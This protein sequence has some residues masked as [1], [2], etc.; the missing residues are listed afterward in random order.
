MGICLRHG[1]YGGGSS[2][3]ACAQDEQRH[4]EQIDEQQRSARLQAE[5][6]RQ[7]AREL[8]ESNAYTAANAWRLRASA[9]TARAKELF[10]AGLY[11]DAK[12]LSERA[13]AEDPG[14]LESRLTLAGALDALED[15]AGYEHAIDAAAHLVGTP[16]WNDASAFCVTLG[17]IRVRRLEGAF[18]EAIRHK[19]RVFS[20]S[21]NGITPRLIEEAARLGWRDEVAV[22][23]PEMKGNTDE[24][25]LLDLLY[26]CE[27]AKEAN[28][29]ALSI[30]NRALNAKKPNSNEWLGGFAAAL[31]LRE[32]GQKWFGESLV[33]RARLWNTTAVVEVLRRFHADE[34]WRESHIARLF[35]SSRFA[36]CVG[37]WLDETIAAAPDRAVAAGPSPSIYRLALRAFDLDD[38]ERLTRI[39]AT[40]RAENDCAALAG[41]TGTET[42]FEPRNHSSSLW[43][44]SEVAVE[45]AQFSFDAWMSYCQGGRAVERKAFQ[46]A[47]DHYRH[48]AYLFK[49]GGDSVWLGYSLRQLGW[50]LCPDRNPDGNWTNAD[51]AFGKAADVAHASGTT[52]TRAQAV[53]GRAWCHEPPNNPAGDWTR[54]IAFYQE[55]AVLAKDAGDQPQEAEALHAQAWCFAH[56]NN[57][58]DKA[59]SLYAR[60][61]RVWE[62]TGQQADVARSLYGQARALARDDPKNVGADVRLLLDRAIQAR[63]AV[64][65]RKGLREIE[66]WLLGGDSG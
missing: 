59:S 65:D 19:L 13:V 16:D 27:C 9:M 37:R 55:A 40:A 31:R 32:H 28:K 60:A 12:N 21:R 51:I 52:R 66:N 6:Q 42:F 24:F 46:T 3:Y 54:C 49:K 14:N 30:V 38:Q 63:R 33:D 47:A 1:D 45:R 5:T 39:E 35:V 25:T 34:S 2:C 20:Q 11:V 57:D 41:A 61:V 48:A 7:T 36:D 58:W 43:T 44:V 8:S 26:G 22:L 64:S 50:S 23:F 29:L 10:D 17:W 62:E 15:H 18:V 4:W 56:R 53:Y